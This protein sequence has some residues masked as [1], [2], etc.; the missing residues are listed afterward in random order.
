MPNDVSIGLGMLD[1]DK[2]SVAVRGLGSGVALGTV[3][4]EGFGIGVL[5][6]SGIVVE[7]VT[8]TSGLSKDVVRGMRGSSDEVRERTGLSVEVGLIIV[9]GLMKLVVGTLMIV[10]GATMS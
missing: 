10:V 9:V 4:V 2:S 7:G 8:D 1:V 3:G 5:S 6:K